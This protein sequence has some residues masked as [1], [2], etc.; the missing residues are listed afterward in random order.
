MSIPGRLAMPSK[1][2]T[3]TIE[4]IYA[5]MLS[6]ARLDLSPPYQRECCWKQV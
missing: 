2:N 1:T 5:E 6:T 3:K 4:T